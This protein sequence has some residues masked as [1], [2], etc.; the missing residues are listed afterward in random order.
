MTFAAGLRA[1]LRQ[2]PN[3]VMVGEIR[4]AETAQIA[5][6]ASLTGH[7]VLTTLHTN[8]AIGAVTRLRD[9]G[10]EPFLIASTLR[11]VIAQRLVRRVC[12]ACRRAEAVDATGAA[13]AGITPGAMIYRAAGC[14]QCGGTGYAVSLGLFE[15][16]RADEGL[17][18]LISANAPEGEL[19]AHAFAN[20]PQLAQSAREAVLR[21]ETTIEEALRI[22]RPEGSR[23]A[24]L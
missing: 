6:Q 8:D 15:L 18:R 13:L 10:I 20:A 5:V 23:H 14:P 22:I 24:D 19:E 1:I 2:N 9:I 7:L 12:M 4:D 11:G 3:V 16:V 17:R 21:G